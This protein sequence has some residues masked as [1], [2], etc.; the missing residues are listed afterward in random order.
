MAGAIGL[1]VGIASQDNTA[2]H[3]HQT[4]R[5][6]GGSNTHEEMGHF[7]ATRPLTNPDFATCILQMAAGSLL[8]AWGLWVTTF[9][10]SLLLAALT[11]PLPVPLFPPWY[12]AW[13]LPLTLLGPW[14]AFTNIATISLSGRCAK[15]LFFGVI[16]VI[17]YGI[18][19]ILIK[20]F[21]S[22]D[23]Q[24]QVFEISMFLGSI[25]IV[26]ATI[27]AFRRAYRCN[28]LSRKA[29]CRAGFVW[30]GIIVL[31]IALRPADL[32]VVA[33]PMILAFSSLSIMPF[34][35]TP[36]AIAWNRHR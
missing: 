15:I 16:A 19:M 36:L 7:L 30:L 32:P 21:V 25:T 2:R 20:E 8:I 23:A 13:Y 31:A 22:V 11:N 10:G 28:L 1:I 35:T 29:Q 17:S 5:D 4:M 3:H 18:G 27:L 24:K 14:I 9:A 34:A 33:Y 6:L 26:G 12:G